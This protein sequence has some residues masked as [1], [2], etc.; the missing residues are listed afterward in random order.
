[1][2]SEAVAPLRVCASTRCCGWDSRTEPLD[3]SGRRGKVVSG[4]AFEF[5]LGV[6]AYTGI[7]I[8]D[9]NATVVTERGGRLTGKDAGPTCTQMLQSGEVDITMAL[10]SHCCGR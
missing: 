9:E 4:L 3:S 10:F 6:E 1:M 2:S 8:L 5:W 7:E